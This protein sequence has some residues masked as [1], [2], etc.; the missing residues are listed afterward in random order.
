MKQTQNLLYIA[1]HRFMQSVGKGKKDEKFIEKI[2]NWENFYT[3]NYRFSYMDNSLLRPT[4]PS[5]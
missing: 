1:L 3:V 5:L 4:G 2:S